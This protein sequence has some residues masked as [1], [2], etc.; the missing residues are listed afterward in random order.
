MLHYIFLYLLE[1]SIF[2][3]VWLI[4][5]IV[6]K[7]KHKEGLIKYL[8][9]SA[10]VFVGVFV[11]TF[12]TEK[13]KIELNNIYN[14]EAKTLTKIEKPKAFFHFKNVTNEIQITDNINFNKVGE[15]NVNYELDTLF[16][17][18]NETAKVHVVDTQA[19]EIILEGNEEYTQS[20]GK[21]YVEPGYKAI[22]L[23]DGDITEKVEILKKEVDDS[24]YYILYGIKDSSGNSSQ[25]IRHIKIVDDIAPVI[26]L[27][28]KGN[29]YLNLNDKY[30]E[31]GAQ[32]V[33]N[34]D[35]DVTDKIAVEGKV[36]TSNVGVYN[37]NYTVS[38][39]NE[40]KTTKTR[41]VTV[42]EQMEIL[43]HDGSNGNKGVVYLT[44]DDGPSSSITPYI[45]D[46]L[47]AKNVKATFFILNYDEI[48]EELVKREFNEGHTVA[49]HGYSHK[50]ADIYRSVETYMENITK[51]QDKIRESIGYNSTITRFPGGSSNTISKKYSE[52]IMTKLCQE[53]IRKGI[54]IF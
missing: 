6:Y 17:K 30:E 28:G 36:D 21:D 32:A 37:I 8:G 24:E 4:G 1:A 25:K 50:Y 53:L 39:L 38:D 5:I 54:Y 52:G 33:D 10:L 19:P 13:P 7:L 43:G 51:L 45:L 3:L 14:I 40:N 29:I 34:K 46:I 31:Q 42:S 23:Y 47:K 41:V 44:F 27:N 11:L 22:D 35:G 20:Y 15:Y 26:T 12:L 49:I 48:G 18:Y 9:V 2:L 16:G